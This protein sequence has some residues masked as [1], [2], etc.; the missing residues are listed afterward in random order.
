MLQFSGCQ[1]LALQLLQFQS[2]R[3]AL[4]ALLLLGAHFAAEKLLLGD[5]AASILPSLKLAS[6][7]PITS[8]TIRTAGYQPTVEAR[9]YTVEGLAD[10]IA[11]CGCST[12]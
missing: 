4:L 5:Q 11:E 6:I 9:T 12:S 7:G 8:R 1:K 3:P 10:A 2:K